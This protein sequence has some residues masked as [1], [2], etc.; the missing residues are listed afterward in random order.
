M[1]FSL[2]QLQTELAPW[3]KHNF[4]DQPAWMPLMG[5]FEELGELCEA[6]EACGL[7]LGDPRSTVDVEDAIADAVVFMGNFC[8]AV[9]FDLDAIVFQT[10]RPISIPDSEIIVGRLAHAFLKLSQGIRGTPAQHRAALEENLQK[11][12]WSLDSFS[13]GVLRRPLLRIVETTWNRVKQRDF[14]KNALT[15]GETTTP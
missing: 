13:E 6:I 3:T 9:G 1:T 8:N 11:L 7:L 12:Y 15:G 4:G 10:P 5:V 14:K 2:H